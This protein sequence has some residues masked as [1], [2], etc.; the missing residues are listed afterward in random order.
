MF[1]KTR[2]MCNATMRKCIYVST[3]L[4]LNTHERCLEKHTRK[5]LI[6]VAPGKSTWLETEMEGRLTFYYKP[7]L[8]ALP[9]ACTHLKINIHL[10]NTHKC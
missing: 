10:K 4:C 5:R 1:L 7:L 3:C 9:S 8:N 6:M 2:C